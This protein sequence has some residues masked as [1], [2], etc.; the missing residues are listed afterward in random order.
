MADSCTPCPNL[1]DPLRSFGATTEELLDVLCV[2]RERAMDGTITPEH[3]GRLDAQLERAEDERAP[4]LHTVE[5]KIPTAGIILAEARA[6][7]DALIHFALMQNGTTFTDAEQRRMVEDLQPLSR[8]RRSELEANL[9][10][11][12]WG[13][14]DSIVWSTEDSDGYSFALELSNKVRRT[15]IDEHGIPVFEIRDE[16]IPDRYVTTLQMACIVNR[17]K[18]TIIRLVSSKVLPPADVPGSG[19]KPS[20]WRWDSVRGILEKEYN[21]TLPVVFPNDKF[22][23]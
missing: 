11:E 13:A 15:G 10:A 9:Q 7:R 16:S 6:T 17:N 5:S 2:A 20:E 12:L 22:R 14:A 3:Q 8:S 18:K 4:M 21:R 23:R 19:G 1:P